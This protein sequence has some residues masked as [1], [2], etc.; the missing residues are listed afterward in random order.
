MLLTNTKVPKLCKAFE[1][2]AS[3]NIKLSKTQLHKIIQPGGFSGRPLGPLISTGLP[4]MKNVLKLLDK[5]VLMP[6][7]FTAAVLVKDAAIHQKRFGSGMAKLIISNEERDDIME[8][9][10]CHE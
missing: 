9:I 5:N 2:D 6:L 3:A 1:N 7:V 4:L 10:K 8:I